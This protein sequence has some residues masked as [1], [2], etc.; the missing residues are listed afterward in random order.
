MGTLVAWELQYMAVVVTT[1]IILA[2]L[3]DCIRIFRRLIFHGVFWMS[4]EDILFWMLASLV[5]FMVCFVEDAGNIRWF[6]V[7]GEILGACMYNCTVGPFF[8]KYVSL[9]LYFP[10]KLVKKTLKKLVESF[11]ISHSNE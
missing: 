1:G 7:C 9:I 8:V 2:V 4:V 11:K 5:T 3:Y 6:A 10:V